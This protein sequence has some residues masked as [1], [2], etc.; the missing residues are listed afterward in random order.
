MILFFFA[1]LHLQEITL[2]DERGNINIKSRMQ[3]KI[4]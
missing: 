4:F 2:T 1:L 3:C